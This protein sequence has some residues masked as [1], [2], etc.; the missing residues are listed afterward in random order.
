MAWQS[1]RDLTLLY[2]ADIRRNH[3]HKVIARSYCDET[4][5]KSVERALS[6]KENSILKISSRPQ[7]SFL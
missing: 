7:T 2:V 6:D 1:S 3:S 5:P 4:L